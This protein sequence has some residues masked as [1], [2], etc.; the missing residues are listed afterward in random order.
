MSRTLR[1]TGSCIVQGQGVRGSRSVRSSSDKWVDE[2]STVLHWYAG[3]GMVRMEITEA[4]SNVND[5]VS[6]YQQYQDATA[7]FQQNMDRNVG[8][9]VA[10]ETLPTSQRAVAIVRTRPVCA[11]ASVWRLAWRLG[12]L[13]VVVRAQ[14][15]LY[16]PHVCLSKDVAQMSV[17]L[18]L[19][20][21]WGR[22]CA[23]VWDPV[24]QRWHPRMPRRAVGKNNTPKQK[25][26]CT[27]LMYHAVVV[28]CR[29][30]KADAARQCMDGTEF[31][32]VTTCT[33]CEDDA[34]W[35]E[36]WWCV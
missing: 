8:P 2:L 26:T 24:T 13:P 25:C 7:I 15:W 19:S 5:L 21:P 33:A 28:T 29:H 34:H 6:E 22:Q 1:I 4:E 16:Q 14:A 12:L 32:Y 11:E 10:G 9:W 20:G 23:W 18:V 35:W 36:W 30:V 17:H 27:D 31:A 3:E